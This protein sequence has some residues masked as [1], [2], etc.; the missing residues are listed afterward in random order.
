MPGTFRCK[1]CAER[2]PGCHDHCE[3]YQEDKALHDKR[4]HDAFVKKQADM[5]IS[6]NLR[7]V[8]DANAKRRK[9]Q[10]GYMKFSKGS[11]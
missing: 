3:K 1:D 6:D 5:Y 11:G 8:Y 4:R 10:S 2:Y 9:D 7:K